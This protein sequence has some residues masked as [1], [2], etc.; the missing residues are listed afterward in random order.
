MSFLHCFNHNQMGKLRKWTKFSKTMGQSTIYSHRSNRH[1]MIFSILWA[2]QTTIE[3][4]TNYTPFHLVL[5]IEATFP[6]KCE[7]QQCDLHL[8]FFETHPPFNKDYLPWNIWMKINTLCY[9]KMNPWSIVPR[10]NMTNG[11]VPMYFMK[12]TLF[13]VITSQLRKFAPISSKSMVWPICCPQMSPK[14]EICLGQSNGM[15]LPHPLNGLVVFETF[16]P[17]K[18]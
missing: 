11:F 5:G 16:L 3:T 1:L 6:M 10:F 12:E 2:Y 14:V 8:N 7:Y 15:F 17:W 18:S 4:T 13:S 9:N